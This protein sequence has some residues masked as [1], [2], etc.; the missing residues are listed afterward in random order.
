MVE[1]WRQ[2]HDFPEYSVSNYGNVRRD[3]NQRNLRVY[4]NQYGVCCVGL[5][6]GGVQY[7]RSVSLIVA[8][9]FI[10]QPKD[11]YDTPINCDG[12]RFNNH[13]DN[14]LWR[15]RWFAIQYNRQFRDP[16]PYPINRPIREVKTGAEF[17]NSFS[18]AQTFG[19]LERDVVLS[20]LNYTVTWPTLQ[21]FETVD[22]LLHIDS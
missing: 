21:V 15:P 17:P 20:I 9:A 1:E 8:R 12:D 13:I 6:R 10:P 22:E 2:V 3:E 16:Y 18:C 4:P 5:V 19:L 14:L 11:T 7:N